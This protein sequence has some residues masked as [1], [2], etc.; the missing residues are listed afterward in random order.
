MVITKGDI[1]RGPITC[2]ADN[3]CFNAVSVHVVY[4]HELIFI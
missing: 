3:L 4:F 1:I 2:I